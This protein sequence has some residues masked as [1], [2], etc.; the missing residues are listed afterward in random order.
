MDSFTDIYRYGQLCYNSDAYIRWF[1]VRQGTRQGGVISP[2][3]YLVYDN[4]LRCQLEEKQ[5][6][7]CVHNINCGRPGVADDKLFLSLSKQGMDRTIA[8]CYYHSGK[9]RNEYFISHH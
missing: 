4:G 3:L 8:M 5:M 7:L 1:P 6:G 9:W 2:F